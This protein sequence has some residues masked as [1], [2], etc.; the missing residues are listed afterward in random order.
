[1]IIMITV[2]K[3]LEKRLGKLEKKNGDHPDHSTD[4][5]CWNTLKIPGKIRRLAV[6]HNLM[7]KM[8]MV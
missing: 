4:K 8:L 5:I 3:G 1:M 6:T 7:K 2:L